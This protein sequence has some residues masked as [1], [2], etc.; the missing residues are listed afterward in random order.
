VRFEV[1]GEKYKRIFHYIED[2]KR[3]EYAAPGGEAAVVRHECIVPGGAMALCSILHETDNT[4]CDFDLVEFRNDANISAKEYVE[5]VLHNK[6]GKGNECN[7]YYTAIRQ[8]HVSCSNVNWETIDQVKVYDFENTDDTHRDKGTVPFLW[9]SYGKLPNE[10]DLK[11][12]CF[13][14][15][16]ANNLRRNGAMISKGISWERSAENLLWQLT[17]NPDMKVLLNAP[18]ILITFSE[19]GAIYI[20]TI[21][22]TN[23]D[24]REL[25]EAWLTL[26]KNGMEGDS[27]KGKEGRNNDTFL[28]KMAAAALQVGA[29][30]NGTQEL[31][32]RA[33]LEAGEYLEKKGYV[34]DDFVEYK[35]NVQCMLSIAKPDENDKIRIP[36]KDS[37][38]IQLNKWNIVKDISKNNVFDLAKNY[39]KRGKLS[40]DPNAV[41]DIK[42]I[43]ILEIGKLKSI[44][45]LEIEHYS[46]IRN[47]MDMY[48][49][50][51]KFKEPLSIAVF[52]QPGSGKTFGVKQI[53]GNVLPKDKTETI[54]CNVTQ[55]ADPIKDLGECFQKVR[56]IILKEKLPLVFFDEFDTDNCRWIKYFLMPM[57]DGEFKDKTGTHPLGR[58]ILVFAGGTAF[59]FDEFR[60]KNNGAKAR[61]KKIP[62]FI[63]RIKDS[64][65]ITGLNQG[66]EEN[67]NYILKRALVLRSKCKDENRLDIKDPKFID[68]NILRAMLLVPYFKHGGRSIENILSMSNITDRQWIPS[69]LPLGDQLSANVKVRAFT[70]L[71]LC[72]TIN[73]E[74][75][76]LLAKKIYEIK[77]VFTDFIYPVRN[78]VQNCSWRYLDDQYKIQYYRIARYYID[79]LAKQGYIIA[80][81]DNTTSMGIK[82]M[83]EELDE[84]ASFVYKQR[85][86]DISEDEQIYNA[87]DDNK[88]SSL[89]TE[90]D[91][92]TIVKCAKLVVKQINAIDYVIIEN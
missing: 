17:Y 45:R 12:N 23:K 37:V 13:L 40:L 88:I 5:L 59:T 25:K 54:S 66:N 47:I 36:I 44:D 67:E 84:L 50:N 76:G 6:D 51:T 86:K 87:T 8:T 38:P 73:K 60:S 79:G 82:L 32:V 27:R 42:N 70:D 58:C 46:N 4:F 7:P 92:K 29:I 31:N 72:K 91:W 55:F 65:D 1:E 10:N 20:K 24:T 15:L 90:S 78:D 11:G 39:V 77:E 61:K 3:Y 85:N 52:G 53:V 48:Y 22:N 18:H 30:F 43:P 33:I 14:M 81:K 21:K 26:T 64:I 80:P 75:L 89:N 83:G 41:T 57:Q 62:D 2:S 49:K 34:K 69:T 63:S 9:A 16:S 68:E 19:D 74:P 28:I 35:Y 71:L 56:D